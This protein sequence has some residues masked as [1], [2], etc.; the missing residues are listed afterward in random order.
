MIYLLGMKRRVASTGKKARFEEVAGNRSKQ[1][2]KQ[3]ET[4]DEKS[5]E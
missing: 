4:V 5:M 2:R 1:S 3:I